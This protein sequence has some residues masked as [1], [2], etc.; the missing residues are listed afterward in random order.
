MVEKK[1]KLRIAQI[2]AIWER[3]PPPKYGGTERVVSYLT[4][5][6][7]QEGHDVTLFACGTSQTSAHLIA[8]YPRPLYRDNIPW[9]N[10][11]YPLLH[12]TE[13]FDHA[14]EFDIIH[15]HLNVS[16]DY[17]SMPLAKPIQHKVIFTM[18]FPYPAT[19]A[20]RD[21][22]L[23]LQKYKHLNFVSISNAQRSGGENLN[24]VATVY[25]GIDVSLYQ[26]HPRPKDYFVWVGKFVPQKGVKEAIEAAR[27][28]HV[29]LILAGTID[30]LNRVGKKYYE[31]EIAP[32]IDGKQIEY[33]GEVSDAQ[34]NDYFGNAIATLNPIQWNEPFGLV[35]T[36]SMACGTP[37]IAFANGAAPEII[38]DGQTGFLV[39]TTK[40][41]VK[42]MK[43]VEKLDR[44][45]CRTRVEQ[46][47]SS[48]T[49]TRKYVE[50][51]RQALQTL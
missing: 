29:K 41:M 2:S 38:T 45:A 42:R 4:E 39:T 37:V 13:V 9:T 40:E 8:T 49:M 21:R 47:F 25:N 32:L 15:M 33:V 46:S 3:T 10:I 22:H 19:Q 11:T 48:E 5:R 24:W 44:Q 36:E 17:I 7:V 27:M 12:I 14:Q 43:D 18:H 28:A 31:E 1:K 16:S 50:V 20:R 35:M 34:K 6:L 23:V 30:T 51:Y 26:F